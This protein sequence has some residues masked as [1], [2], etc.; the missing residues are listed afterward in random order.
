[1]HAM[2]IYV[3]ITAMVSSSVGSESPCCSST[4]S[5]E[6]ES[7]DERMPPSK[8]RKTAKG[9]HLNRTSNLQRFIG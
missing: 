9:C 7:S 8:K 5:S 4:L 2:F 3:L 6:Q 1:M